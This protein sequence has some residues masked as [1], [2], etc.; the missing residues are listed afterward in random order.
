MKNDDATK[1]ITTQ[2]H[3]GSVN[4]KKR[5]TNLTSWRQEASPLILKK[6]TTRA[7]LLFG[8]FLWWNT[9]PS[10]PPRLPQQV[11]LLGFFTSMFPGMFHVTLQ[12]QI[13]SFNL[14]F[15]DLV[16]LVSLLVGDLQKSR[17]LMA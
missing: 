13:W 10:D 16:G 3:E 7:K 9:I 6:Q 5:Q 15:G 14:L 11:I 1:H 2:E 4:T 17:I 8:K 12:I